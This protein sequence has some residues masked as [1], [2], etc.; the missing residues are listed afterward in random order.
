[1]P[2]P[3]AVTCHLCHRAINW[4]VFGRSAGHFVRQLEGRESIIWIGIQRSNQPSVVRLKL[5]AALLR[6]RLNVE[7][8]LQTSLGPVRARSGDWPN[9]TERLR[10]ENRGNSQWVQI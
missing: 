8:T 10:A 5:K 9:I 2:N 6:H 4:K 7:N 1:M 3:G